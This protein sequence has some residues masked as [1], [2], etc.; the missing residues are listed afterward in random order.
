MFVYHCKLND[1]GLQIQICK[2]WDSDCVQILPIILSE[3]WYADMLNTVCQ[4]LPASLSTNLHHLKSSASEH[5][6]Y[7]AQ[8]TQ[9][10]KLNMCLQSKTMTNINIYFGPYQ[11]VIICNECWKTSFVN[12][13]FLRENYFC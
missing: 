2:H 6:F 5:K 10:S 9:I 8:V 1:N 11:L 13:D 4:M 12:V 3:F 7:I